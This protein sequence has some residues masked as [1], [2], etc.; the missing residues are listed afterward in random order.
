MTSP[1]QA[2]AIVLASDPHFAGIGPL[3]RDLIGQASW[4]E[5]AQVADGFV[6]TVRMGWG[7]CMAGCIS[8][9]RWHYHVATDGTLEFTAEDGDPI[10]G[11][12]PVPD[13]SGTGA[14]DIHVVAGPTC[15]VQTEPPQPGCEPRDVAGSTIVIRDPDGAEVVRIESDETG[16][17]RAELP[18]GIYIVEAQPLEGYM[19]APEPV[20]AW[21]LGEEP[22]LVTLEY[23]TGIL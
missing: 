3:A 7:D 21:A 10:E 11:A 12:L 18:A 8:S 20:A 6:V 17:A 1:A 23:E 14:F 4:Y 5:V 2:A 22:G 16:H 15:P 13:V 19:A 9:H